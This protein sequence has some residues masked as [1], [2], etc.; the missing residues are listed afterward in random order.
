MHYLGFEDLPYAFAD[1]EMVFDEDSTMV[2]WIFRYGNP[3]MAEL[4]RYP[5]DDF[6]GASFR[7][8]MMGADTKWLPLYERCALF[9]EV[10][11]LVDYSPELDTYLKICC[12]PTFSGHCG[13]IISDVSKIPLFK[14]DDPDALTGLKVYLGQLK[15]REPGSFI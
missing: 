1:V 3:A 8:V 7:D 15:L 13:C 6:V 10:L 12:F 14:I 11:E 4:E 2:D 5:L 9:G